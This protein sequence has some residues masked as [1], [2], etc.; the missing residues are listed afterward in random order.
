M[1][2]APSPTAAPAARPSRLRRLTLLALLLASLAAAGTFG[3][4][5]LLYERHLRAAREAMD[6]QDCDEARP[7]LD[8]CLRLRA[9]SAEVHFVAARGLRRAGYYDEAA[10]RLRECER[11]G[12]QT[13]DTL[14]EWAMLG[15]ERG[16][17]IENE[18]FLLHR[19][20]E[21]AP[22]KPLILE[23]L[24]QGNID[25]YH[26]GRARH[27]L[28]ELLAQDPDSALGLMWMGWL[29]ETSGKADAALANY[30]RALEVH[31]RQPAVRLRLAQ[32]ALVHDNVDEAVGHLTE[33]RRR[34]YKP[35][36]VL[37]ALA[38]CRIQ[39]GDFAEAR[40]LLDE[41]LADSPDDSGALLERGKLA[42]QDG[43]PE[44]AER[45]L[46][47]AAELTP[48]DRV[49]LK[50][51]VEALSAQG[52]TGQAEEVATR[53][54]H[55]EAEQRRLEEVFKRMG[56]APTEPHLWYEAGVICLRNGQLH[57]A[58]R[59]LRGALQLDPAYAPAH[60]SLAELYQRVGQPDLAARHR[61]LAAVKR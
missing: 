54:K 33:L 53:L 7:H 34:R 38:R 18:P 44:G 16:E 5:R 35:P 58:E 61:R 47:R 48:Q 26:L 27:Y 32:L 49:A 57:E 23:A 59:W 43:N 36:E 19:L 40:S 11:L 55:V 22:E 20:D 30:R 13:P 14:L 2:P 25:T 6:E 42:L 41:L 60:E 31:P 3:G 51:L 8:A 45:R 28:D 50:S 52:K 24:A 17:L 10:D 9:D 39:Q 37:L 15:A 46:R 12:G 29:Y 4:R 21:G 56:E 1:D